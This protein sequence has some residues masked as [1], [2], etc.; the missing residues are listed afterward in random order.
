MIFDNLRV[1]QFE[2]RCVRFIAYWSPNDLIGQTQ[3]NPEDTSVLVKIACNL[4]WTR[5]F[6]WLYIYY[7]QVIQGD[8]S[9]QDGKELWV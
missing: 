9:Y 4:T 7:K 8:R 5:F 2:K 3:D 6:K 1:Q